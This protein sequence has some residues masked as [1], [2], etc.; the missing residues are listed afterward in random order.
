VLNEFGDNTPTSSSASHR[1]LGPSTSKRGL[2]IAGAV[3]VVFVALALQAS[4]SGASS[5]SRSL[6]S[7]ASGTETCAQAPEPALTIPSPASSSGSASSGSAS[8]S[9]I[10]ATKAELAAIESEIAAEQLCV[11]NLSEQYDTSTYRVQQLTSSIAVNKRRL[12]TSKV[13]V[14]LV[15]HQVQSAVLNSYMYDETAQ[16][17]DLLF[18][19]TSVTASLESAYTS[20]ALGNVTNDLHALNVAKQRFEATQNL[21]V[22]ERTQAASEASAASTAEIAATAETKSTE[23]ILKEV[24]GQLATQVAAEA[25][26]Q[27]AEDAAQVADAS[28]LRL[29][30]ADA[31]KA[32]Q[33]AQ[34]AETLGDGSS[35]AASAGKAGSGAGDQTG[36][37]PTN[38]PTGGPGAA[39]VE[40]AESYLGVPYVWGGA[41]RAGVDCS[42][43]VMLAWS[44]AGVQ[45]A[46]SA[47]IQSEES[48]PVSLS[49]LQPGDLLFYD[50]GGTG[51][52]HVV[53]YVGSGPYGSNTIIQ[54]AH[55]GTVV[56]FDSIYY[57]G[58]VGAGMP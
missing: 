10:H 7:A 15:R 4:P 54:A 27:A 57:E 3:V 22:S 39:A 35:A 11:T 13:D 24:K 47:A 30:Q 26:A 9:S 44:A 34:V 33:A 46:H 45:L 25:A 2:R 49:E 14:T 19:G 52:D 8:G 5:L 40:A 12:A 32:E 31:L 23:T 6:Q 21:L 38:P 58:L 1:D 43:L 16:Q 42:G 41:S 37:P 36:T 51:I 20:D 48:T 29:K 53:M 55:T 56:S 18:S 50:F 28:S 17:L